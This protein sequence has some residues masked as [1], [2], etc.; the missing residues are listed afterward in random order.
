MVGELPD[1]SKSAGQTFV[2]LTKL[3]DIEVEFAKM[4]NR[5][6]EA[7]ISND[8]NV[9][10]LVEQLCTISAVSNKNVP[11]F[12]EDVFEKVK[13]IDEFWRRL[14]MFW[15]IFD[16][17]LPQFVIKISEC[18]EAQ[19]IFEEFLSRI[20]PSAIEDV[21]LVL[22]C[23]VEERVGSLKPVLRNKVNAEKCSLDVVQEVKKIVSETYDLK[24][25]SLRFKG[26]KEGCI[27][28]SYYISKA[29][30]MHFLQLKI[31]A[32]IL[33]ELSSCKIISLNVNNFELK[34]PSKI[35]N[36]TVSVVYSMLSYL[37]LICSYCIAIHNIYSINFS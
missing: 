21:D 27:E 35:I 36:I 10:S 26:I 25:Y 17:D 8:I 1:S 3:E 13:S 33:A 24:I 15:N 31:T 2:Q 22:H 6:K 7:L 16:Y 29:M 12:D 37:T 28:L 18:R 20:D 11:L 32:S 4:T 9:V 30:T 23:R 34:M 19:V 5:I 14:R